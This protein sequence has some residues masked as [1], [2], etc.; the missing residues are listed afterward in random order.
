MR[1]RWAPALC[2]IPVLLGIAW[3]SVRIVADRRFAA[4]L[5]WAMKE[6]DAGRFDVARRWLKA[7]PP[8][9]LSDPEVAG[10]LGACE[11][12]AGNFEAA[13]AS[14]S[15]VPANSPR[16]YNAVLAR[17]HTLIHNLGRFAEA[18]AILEAGLRQPGRS[19]L[20]IR[21]DLGQLYFWESR[22]SAIRRLIIEGRREWQDPAAELRNLWLTD[23][24]TIAVEAVRST[25]A[26]ARRLAPKDDRVWLAQAG[27]AILEGRFDEAKLRLEDC[28]QKRP[29]DPA[30][31]EAWLKLARATGD[32]AG[33]Q[34][35]LAHLPADA[36][37]E[38]EILDVGAWLAARRGDREDER[39]I[40]ERR[41]KVG[42]VDLAAFERLAALYRESGQPDRSALLRQR[43]AELDAIKDRYRRLLVEHVPVSHFD[44]PAALAEALDRPIEAYGWWTLA[45]GQKPGD[46]AAL[47]GL[48]R[49]RKHALATPR[50]MSGTL[51]DRMASLLP[52]GAG[53]PLPVGGPVSQARATSP[54]PVLPVFRDDAGSAGLRF[55]FDNGQSFL[56]QLPETTAG[57]VGLLDYDGDGWLDVYVVQGGLFPPDATHPNT[58]DRLFRNQ[59]D[60]TFV[61]V[62]ERSGIARM[63]RGYGHGVT[64]GDMD[65]DGHPDLFITRWRSYALY[66]NRGDGIFEDFTDARAGRRSRLADLGGIRR[67]R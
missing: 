9:R 52:A 23:D 32:A 67:L 44:E 19:R 8:S 2:S 47:D 27:L 45:Y 35:A 57:G 10:L 58:G 4:G 7:L 18:E 39:Q 36:L 59:G 26:A 5:T 61:D 28:R 43:K 13:L 3:C 34:R 60:G 30:V 31:W 55:I 66:H 40:L 29:N 54:V 64:V 65:N 48:A 1:R 15:L 21:H 56:R 6:V 42:P 46:T 20:E 41:I 63:R 24:G 12:A 53:G 16:G 11:Q 14:W 25:V 37:L 33:A 38:S 49:L 17:A 62:T 22:P 51:L 50:I